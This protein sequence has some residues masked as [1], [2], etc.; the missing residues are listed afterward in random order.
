MDE[1]SDTDNEVPIPPS[2]VCPSKCIIHCV[3][4]PSNNK[5]ISPKDMLSWQSFLNA[6]KIRGH[7]AILDIADAIPENSFPQERVYYHRDCRSKFTLKRD[8]KVIKSS[9]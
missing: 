1:Q 2:G 9:E 3:Q 8:L 6:A 7:K 5:L 4:E